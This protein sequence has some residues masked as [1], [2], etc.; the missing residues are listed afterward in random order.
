LKK[1]VAF[2]RTIPGVGEV[3][4]LTWALEICD[5]ARFPSVGDAVSC[6][7]LTSAQNASA[8]K[9]KHGPISKQRNAHLQTVSLEAAKL[10]PRWNRQ[11]AAD[12]PIFGRRFRRSG[13]RGWRK[14]YGELSK[15]R[16]CLTGL[17]SAI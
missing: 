17:C 2:L 6:C 8:G 15:S 16:R 14:N 11:L 9:E 10:A 12:V 1:L 7:G 4:A 5:P 13:G 3:T